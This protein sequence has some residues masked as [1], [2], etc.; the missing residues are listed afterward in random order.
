VQ[1]IR[2][3]LDELTV[4]SFATGQLSTQKGTVQARSS[5]GYV[6]ACT[7][8]ESANPFCY[9]LPEPGPSNAPDVC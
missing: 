8:N 4:E 2:L 3:V 5:E 6:G 1:K 7:A 9:W